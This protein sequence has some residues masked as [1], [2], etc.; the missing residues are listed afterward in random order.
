M[1]QANHQQA[2]HATAES[3][4][5]ILVVEPSRI[6]WI[7]LQRLLGDVGSTELSFCRVSKLTDAKKESL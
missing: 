2:E 5:R 6:N 4:K 1:Q 3:R 7:G